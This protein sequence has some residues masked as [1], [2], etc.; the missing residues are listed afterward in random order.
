[1]NQNEINYKKE[2]WNYIFKVFPLVD[3]PFNA[4]IIY[5]SNNWIITLIFSL[6]FPAV[7]S[8]TL[9]LSQKKNFQP[10]Y[11]IMGINGILFIPFMYYSGPNSPTWLN[12]IVIT[13]GSSF[14]FNNPRI[15]Q[16]VI[17]TWSFLVGWFFIS[18][19]QVWNIL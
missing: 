10:G 3:L 9:F 12:I 14:M 13:V 17:A 15:G 1:M 7:A 6:I 2:Q 11:W 5:L 19:A 4:L 16:F 8:I 18:L